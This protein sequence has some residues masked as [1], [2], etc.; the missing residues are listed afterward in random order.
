[1]YIC[2]FECERSILYVSTLTLEVTDISVIAKFLYFR[3][4][5]EPF[6]T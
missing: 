6:P 4:T 1:M 5:T 2:G 3:L